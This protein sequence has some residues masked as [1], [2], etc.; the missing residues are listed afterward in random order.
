VKEYVGVPYASL[1][2]ESGLD[3]LG[4]DTTQTYEY[5]HDFVAPDG[6]IGVQETSP[7]PVESFVFVDASAEQAASQIQV[8]ATCPAEVNPIGSSQ[9]V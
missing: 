5:I 2:L 8:R 7:I 9:C 3:V 6:A 1:Q 4:E